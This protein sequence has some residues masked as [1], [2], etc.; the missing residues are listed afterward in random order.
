MIPSDKII[1]FI[2]K[3]EGCRLHAYPDQR[4]IP[5]IGVGTIVYKNGNRVKLGDTI[6]LEQA[7]DLLMWQCTLKTLAL[8]KMLGNYKLNQNRWDSLLSFIYNEGVGGLQKSTLLKKVKAN[9]DDPTIKDAFYVY[10]KVRNKDTGKL[11]FNQGLADR[12]MAEWEIYN[13]KA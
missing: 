5:T 12:R 10:N 4:G 8:N 13:S 7:E 2:R 1:D 6:T 3:W 9:P 11:E